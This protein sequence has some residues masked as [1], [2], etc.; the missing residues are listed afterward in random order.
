MEKERTNEC[1]RERTCVGGMAY[2]VLS[3]GEEILGAV[4]RYCMSSAFC[5]LSQVM[6]TRIT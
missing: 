6:R 3:V 1:G 2:G 4:S 5:K